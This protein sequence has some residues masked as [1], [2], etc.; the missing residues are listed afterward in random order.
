MKRGRAIRDEEALSHIIAT[1]IL[2]VI[3]VAMAVAYWVLGSTR[4][5]R[6]MRY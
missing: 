2:V 1:I 5:S 3:S 6:G 4:P